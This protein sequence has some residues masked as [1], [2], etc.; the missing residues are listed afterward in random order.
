M[1][2]VGVSDSNPSLFGTPSEAIAAFRGRSRSARALLADEA[3][4]SAFHDRTARSLW[5]YLTRAS[6]DSSLAQ[7]VTQESYLRLLR[8]DFQPESE[9]HL[10][11]YLFRIASNL[12]RDHHRRRRPAG[13]IE[14][15][16]AVP[17]AAGAREIRQDLTGAM[18][19]LKPRERQVLWL[20]HVEGARHAEIAEILNLAP[21]SIRVIAFRARQRMAALLREG[22]IT[23][24]TTR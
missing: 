4:F 23:P 2:V 15:E 6:G 1:S 17:S 20:A 8:A 18:A 3:T 22:G 9:L 10:R 14:G 19:K 21:A 12:L 7:D 13:E 11:H 5:A 24:E 16:P